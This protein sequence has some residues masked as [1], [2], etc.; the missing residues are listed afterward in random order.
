MRLPIAVSSVRAVR[1][2]LYR[3]LSPASATLRRL[4][5]LPELPPLWLRRH[6]GPIRSFVPSARWTLNTLERLEI[7]RPGMRVL[8]LGCGC[9]AMA[10]LVRSNLGESGSFIGIDVHGPSIQ[11][12]QEHFSN[13]ERLSFF[14]ADLD[15]PYSAA[16]S[17]RNRAADRVED[18]VL[19][20]AD[21]VL[22]LVLAKSLF[23]HLLLTE[24]RSYFREIGRTLA[25]NGRA[26]LTFFAFETVARTPAF[27]YPSDAAP[28]RWRR[29]QHPRAAVAYSRELI[30]ELLSDAGLVVETFLPGFF[31]GSSA[32]LS[33]Q[34][35]I[36]AK[37]TV[38]SSRPRGGVS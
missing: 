6:T 19:P 21:G 14:V 29:R 34:D 32:R 8:D 17:S 23:T 33:G 24:T 2:L 20:L 1:E 25:P 12:C 31:P 36:V 9:G 22:D 4:R 15:S 28:V 3:C 11:W 16:S 27:P 5:G 37:K 26:L 35:Q 13:D 18:Y 7:I 38:A 30:E 10:A